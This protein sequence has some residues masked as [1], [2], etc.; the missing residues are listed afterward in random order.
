MLWRSIEICETSS[1]FILLRSE[2]NKKKNT[3]SNPGHPSLTLAL[4]DAYAHD[5]CKLAH[6][7]YVQ[8][9]EEYDALP[10]A[11]RF[12]KWRSQALTWV[13]VCSRRLGQNGLALKYLK[14]SVEFHAT[15]EARYH[16]AASL[17]VARKIRES[18]DEIIRA[19]MM[20]TKDE[21]VQLL[22][23]LL[24][25]MK[26]W[27]LLDR[28]LHH[29]LT[30]ACTLG[31]S[32]YPKYRILMERGVAVESLGRSE[33][34]Q[35][36]YGTA[37]ALSGLSENQFRSELLGFARMVRENSESVYGKGMEEAVIE[38]DRREVSEL[39]EPWFEETKPAWRIIF[40]R[41][42]A[43][44]WPMSSVLRNAAVEELATQR[45]IFEHDP[46]ATL[47]RVVKSFEC[48]LI[49]LFNVTDCVFAAKYF[50]RTQHD[51]VRAHGVETSTF[52][53]SNFPELGES[54]VLHVGLF[55]ADLRPHP[56]FSLVA[57]FVK[58]APKNRVKVT[59]FH[60]GAN[61]DWLSVLEP[62]VAASH[63]V[64]TSAIGET[65]LF[66]KESKIH[67]WLETTGHTGLGLAFLASTRPAPVGVLW[68]G[69]PGSVADPALQYMVADRF[70]VP[71]G[72]ISSEYPE[73][74]IYLPGTW[75][76]SDLAADEGISKNDSSLDL[77]GEVPVI[78]RASV[79]KSM[80]IPQDAFVFAN[81]GRLWKIGDETLDVWCEIIAQVPN[82][83]LVLV[84]GLQPNEPASIVDWVK[85]V[86]AQHGLEEHRLVIT[87][88][89]Q[90]GRHIS[91]LGA[92]ADVALD[93]WMY[94]GGITAVE[95][96]YS[97][98]PLVHRPGGDKFIQRAGGSA[99]IAAGLEDIIASD[100]D[101]YKSVAV[102]L[103]MDAEYYAE[104]KQRVQDAVEGRGRGILF[105]PTVQARALAEGLREAYSIWRAG[106]EY[107]PIFVDQGFTPRINVDS[108][109][110]FVSLVRKI[111]LLQKE[112]IVEVIADDP[113]RHENRSSHSLRSSSSSSSSSESLSP[114]FG[115][116]L[117]TLSSTPWSWDQF[118]LLLMIHA[119]C[120]DP[121]HYE[122]LVTN[123]RKAAEGAVPIQ[124]RSVTLRAFVFCT[125][126]NRRRMDARKEDVTQE[127]TTLVELI[128]AVD[129]SLRREQ[130]SSL[131]ETF[132]RKI[133]ILRDLAS[134]QR[135][136]EV[137]VAVESHF[138]KAFEAHLNAVALRRPWLDRPFRV[139]PE[140]PPELMANRS[141]IGRLCVVK[142]V[143][144]DYDR[145]QPITRA[146]ASGCVD[147]YLFTDSASAEPSGWT[148]LRKPFHLSDTVVDLGAKNS[149]SNSSSMDQR[150]INYLTNKYYRML[151]WR[152]PHLR[153]SCRYILYV[154]GN[155]DVSNPLLY[156]AI[157][158]GLDG[159]PMLHSIHEA[160][161]RGHNVAH[162]TAAAMV[163][164][165]YRLDNVFGQYLDYVMKQGFTDTVAVRR[166][167]FFVYDARSKNALHFQ[168]ISLFAYTTNKL[169]RCARAR[170]VDIVARSDSALVNRGPSFPPI[171]PLET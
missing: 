18:V 165:R 84:K 79:R 130:T 87:Q 78:T 93:T 47:S 153:A 167:T 112:K 139:L 7:L 13:G 25:S 133:D 77:G 147:Y 6:P 122:P 90:K 158:D 54:D 151:A 83:V 127:Y 1:L 27:E 28:V 80:D 21:D 114:S 105:R 91:F 121:R 45:V 157:L 125:E 123:C 128:L 108:N 66:A 58:N 126:L 117:Q 44:Q 152:V 110:T 35:Q 24:G 162:E 116:V 73:K 9:L 92:L 67:V 22:S 104:V 96:L 62:F 140:E 95:A 2:P 32:V 150:K 30:N 81:F 101:E 143:F 168:I 3:N 31:S 119:A 17:A 64:N 160:W 69:F 36:Y 71:P 129:P 145:V 85:R 10:P 164:P 70:S 106:E 124:D 4:A 75:L 16:L 61:P 76:F 156:E 161:I 43:G 39:L 115:D 148:V 48:L 163:Q 59:L 52:L 103:G 56:M 40:D 171:C 55:S 46:S 135:N 99:L 82:S 109:G 65:L 29:C 138:T 63:A 120:S 12:W 169:A 88:R 38:I 74:M 111:P 53:P 15:H 8:V 49:P 170:A 142:A 134:L 42:L 159:N 137:C 166:G 154:D 57:G 132:T 102:R 60:R 100:I 5:N 68:A 19:M 37:H 136:R 144:G 97:G 131:S 113:I 51:D 34:A 98:L 50:A 20:E 118:E 89:F 14:K 107:R 86:W 72:V 94:G 26:A 146:D 141:C 23:N 33:E 41:I 11:W 155:V 149:F